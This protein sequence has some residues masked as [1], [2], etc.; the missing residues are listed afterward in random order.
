MIQIDLLKIR[1]YFKMWLPYIMAFIFLILWIFK[2]NDLSDLKDENNS[3]ENSIVKSEILKSGYLD[4]INRK[5][6][7][8]SKKDKKIDSL[9]TEILTSKQKT[10]E[11]KKESEKKQKEVYSYSTEKLADFYRKKYSPKES[12]QT[13]GT[14]IVTG[15]TIA[16][17][18]VSDLVEKEYVHLELNQTKE[19]LK[20]TEEK[21]KQQDS[22]NKD[23]KFQKDRLYMIIEEDAKQ[24]KA[25]DNIISS[26]KHSLETEKKGKNFWKGTAIGATALLVIKIVASKK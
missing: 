18:I 11:I 14:D 22:V 5:D 13:I 10:V 23:L 19:T 25:K 12:I 24:S 7:E 9:N 2:K 15:D 17:Q 26:T 1:D 20:I 4:L 3:L 16:K 21:S 6:K 8:I